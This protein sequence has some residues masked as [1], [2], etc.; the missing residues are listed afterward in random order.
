MDNVKMDEMMS[1]AIKWSTD[2]QD[3]F[4][5]ATELVQGKGPESV[6]GAMIGLMVRP[7]LESFKRFQD[8]VVVVAKEHVETQD[9]KDDLDDASPEEVA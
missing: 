2:G 8:A 7:A 4:R 6:M 1:K 5:D 3:L 9:F